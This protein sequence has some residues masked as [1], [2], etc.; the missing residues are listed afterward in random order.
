MHP[1][2]DY[3]SENG[4]KKHYQLVI[5]DENG[6]VS[7]HGC[8]YDWDEIQQ[9]VKEISELYAKHGIIHHVGYREV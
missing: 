8:L 7:F 3:D 1:I 9:A 5:M 6:K 4:N 2:F